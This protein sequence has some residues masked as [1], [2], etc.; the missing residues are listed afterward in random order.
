MVIMMVMRRMVTCAR[1]LF[2]CALT[3]IVTIRVPVGSRRQMQMGKVVTV[4]MVM[5]NR[6]ACG[7]AASV[8]EDQCPAARPSKHRLPVSDQSARCFTM[9]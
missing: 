9:G 3:A 5:E 4:V 1:S 2:G 6:A 8:K 7:R